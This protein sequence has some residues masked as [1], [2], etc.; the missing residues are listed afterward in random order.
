MPMTLEKLAEEAAQY[1]RHSPRHAMQNA[2]EAMADGLLARADM[3]WL[4]P[5]LISAL[6]VLGYSVRKKRHF[7]NSSPVERK[8]TCIRQKRQP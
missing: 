4:A 1:E 6:D 7:A 5:R 3:E 2:L 8:T